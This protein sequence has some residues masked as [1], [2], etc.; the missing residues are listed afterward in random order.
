[1]TDAFFWAAI[2]LIVGIG[3]IVLEMFVPSGGL[4]PA[5]S[6]MVTTPHACRPTDRS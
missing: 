6:L 3:L 5:G 4:L 2:L 1:M